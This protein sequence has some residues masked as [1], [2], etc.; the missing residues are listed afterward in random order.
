[1]KWIKIFLGKMTNYNS[2]TFSCWKFKSQD[3]GLT[4]KASKSS[5]SEAESVSL[6][7]SSEETLSVSLSSSGAGCSSSQETK[8]STVGV[9]LPGTRLPPAAEGGTGNGVYYGN[10]LKSSN[11]EKSSLRSW[12][13]FQ[14]NNFCHG[15]LI[16]FLWKE[17]FFYRFWNKLAPF[18]K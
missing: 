3:I 7:P 2:F 11:N 4:S 6:S 13:K 5:Y 16:T 17:N 10:Y 15:H 9:S 1:M 8:A 18:I 14:V 12:F